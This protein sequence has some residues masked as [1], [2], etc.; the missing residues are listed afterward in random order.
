M[1]L[2]V[3]RNKAVIPP[4]CPIDEGVKLLAGA[5]APHV[6]WYLSEQPRRFSELRRDIP[7]ISARVLSARL[8]E[9]KDRG[10]ITRTP[11]STSPPSAEY[12]LTDLGRLLLPALTALVGVALKLPPVA[13]GKASPARRPAEKARRGRRT[14]AKVS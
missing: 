3:R 11:L 9:L 14:I 4:A 7:E 8:R 2:R 10:I 12:A 6:I 5:W 13:A 1:A